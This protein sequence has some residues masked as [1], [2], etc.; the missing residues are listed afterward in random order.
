MTQRRITV[1]YILSAAMSG[2]GIWFFA[3]A[4]AEA[5]DLF[6]LSPPSRFRVH[7]RSSSSPSRR[8][9]AGF[10]D[11]PTEPIAHLA[12]RL[13][14]QHRPARQRY[15]TQQSSSYRPP[16]LGLAHAS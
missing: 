11:M 12:P 16:S 15:A 1:V 14:L 5:A 13:Q 6:G 3:S 4:V 9:V 2:L 10:L 7:H 8:L